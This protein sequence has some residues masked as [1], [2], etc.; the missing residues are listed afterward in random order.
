MD[1]NIN[2]NLSDYCILNTY[3][4]TSIS[5]KSYTRIAAKIKIVCDFYFICLNGASN[6]N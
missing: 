4:N 1:E 5:K 6:S 3:T 2:L